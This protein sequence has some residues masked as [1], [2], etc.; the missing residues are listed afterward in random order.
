MKVNSLVLFFFFF[1]LHLPRDK[2]IRKENGR[3]RKNVVETR[4][5]KNEAER[6]RVNTRF[7]LASRISQIYSQEK[8]LID[9]QYTPLDRGVYLKRVKNG[10][11]EKKRK[12]ANATFEDGISYNHRAPA[13]RTYAHLT[14]AHINVFIEWK[15]PRLI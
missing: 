4:Q 15:R 1:L 6:K 5:R 10:K 3:R 14:H 8:F 13:L 9:C 2:N 7:H 11:Q 12:K